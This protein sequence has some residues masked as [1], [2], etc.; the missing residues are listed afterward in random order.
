MNVPCST[1]SCA[2]PSL[3]HR[4]AERLEDIINN[5]TI[6]ADRERWQEK[7]TNIQNIADEAKRHAQLANLLIQLSDRR[8][9]QHAHS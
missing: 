4:L 1:G 6:D 5:I 8:E 2:K 3:L 7:L 9:L